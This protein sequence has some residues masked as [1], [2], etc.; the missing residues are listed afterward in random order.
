MNRVAAKVLA[1]VIVAV[2]L[3]L[4]STPAKAWNGWSGGPGGAVQMHWMYGGNNGQTIV[5]VHG[6]ADCSTWLGDCNSNAAGGWELSYWTNHGSSGNNQLLNMRFH[7]SGTYDV[8]TIGYDLVNNGFWDSAND[9]GACLNDLANGTNNSGCNPYN[10]QRS[11][12]HIVTHSAGATVMDRLLSTGWWGINSHVLSDVSAIAPAL[13]GS[14][15]SSVLYNQMNSNG[16]WYCSNPITNGLVP[17]F[18]RWALGSNGAMSLTRGTVLGEANKG[19]AGRSDHWFDKV[20]SYGGSGSA[21]NNNQIGVNESDN[22]TEMGLL[23]CYLGYSSS[24]DMDGLLY[25][26]DSDPTNNTGGN[27]CNTSELL[28]AVHWALLALVHDLGEPQPQ[29]RRCVCAGLVGGLLQPD[30]RLDGAGAGV[31]HR[32]QSLVVSLR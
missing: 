29:P 12:F 13:T 2:G 25:W 20:V 14:Y 28:L 23:A 9:V 21:N 16:A 17:I 24:D 26:S 3:L 32:E 11:S 6:K 4:F 22:D 30:Q 18:G 10:Y 15:A 7:G 31:V 19:Y 27:G 5:F 8:F 1:C